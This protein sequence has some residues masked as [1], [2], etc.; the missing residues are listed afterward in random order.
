LYAIDY[1]MSLQRVLSPNLRCLLLL[2]LERLL[3]VAPYH[4]DRQK[5]T[6]NGGK[7][8]DEDD[9]YADGPDAWREERVKGVILVHEWLYRISGC[10]LGDN[11]Y[12]EEHE[13]EIP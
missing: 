11:Q 5:A 2:S 4:N 13:V 10:R 8:D 9:R 1:L 7:E 12:L 6:D 3:P